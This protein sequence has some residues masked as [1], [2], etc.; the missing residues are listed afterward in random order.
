MSWCNMLCSALLIKSMTHP[1]LKM[2]AHR[3]KIE[4]SMPQFKIYKKCKIKFF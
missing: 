3:K 2:T 1:G 4:L